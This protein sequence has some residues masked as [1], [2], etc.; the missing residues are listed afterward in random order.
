MRWS[1]T[2][3][4]AGL[5]CWA[6]AGVAE[7]RVIEGVAGGVL[8]HSV[9]ASDI[10]N[11]HKET[12]ADFQAEIQFV[13]PS[14]LDWSYIHPYAIVSLNTNGDTS[15]FGAGWNWDFRWG[16]NDRWGFQP[17]LGYVIHN[18]DTT[19]PY[20]VGHPEYGPYFNTH[21]LLGSRDLFRLG[22][23]TSRKF[24]NKIEGQ[25][26]LEHLSHGFI[27]GDEVNQGVDNLGVRLI[28]KFDK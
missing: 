14:V 19:D 7:A 1:L 21:L 15:Y 2:A 10:K 13:R 22:L 25:V 8:V 23:A 28:Y 5:A 12:G 17:I 27:I 18:G 20:P 4:A 3:V 26:L 16:E 11:S 6:G 9:P 24:G